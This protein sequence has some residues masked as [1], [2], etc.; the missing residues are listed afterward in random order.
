MAR[1]STTNRG[2]TMREKL[3]NLFVYLKE[4]DQIIDR[5]GGVCHKRDGTENQKLAFLQSQVKFDF[6]KAK[7]YPVPARYKMVVDGKAT[8]G[9]IGYQAFNQLA[10]IGK[11]IEFFEE[12]FEDLGA[13]D[14]PLMCITVIVDGQPRIEAVEKV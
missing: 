3:F 7:R 2:Q 10:G 9:R 1:S 4:D 13:G 14:S 11:Q 5:I 8:A 6:S 12:V